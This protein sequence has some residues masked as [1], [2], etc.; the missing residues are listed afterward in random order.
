MKMGVE[1]HVFIIHESR[2]SASISGNLIIGQKAP[3]ASSTRFGWRHSLSEHG[4]KEGI[5]YPKPQLLKSAVCHHT[6]R[7]EIIK[8]TKPTPLL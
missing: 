8:Y 6:H 4:S 7:L 3:G 2:W 1:L 5:L